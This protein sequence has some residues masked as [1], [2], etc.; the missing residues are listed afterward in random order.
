M[1]ITKWFPAAHLDFYVCTKTGLQTY[2]I[3]KIFDLHQYYW[4]NQTKQKLT[5]GDNAYYI[6]PSNLY[7]ENSL[8]LI[9]S[10]FKVCKAPIIAPILRNGV[11]CKNILL[12]RLNG[13]KK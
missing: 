12:F 9:K 3:G 4:S 10:Q 8:K 1:V 5:A 11:I 2:G 6:I 7:D 13:Y